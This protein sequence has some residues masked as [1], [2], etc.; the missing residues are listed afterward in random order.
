MR[1][2]RIP[3]SSHT[4]FGANISVRCIL[5][6]INY[7]IESIDVEQ[8][9]RARKN[10]IKKNNTKALWHAFCPLMNYRCV[11][12][13]QL[14]FM[15]LALRPNTNTQ[16]LL[17]SKIRSLTNFNG[18]T[19]KISITTIKLIGSRSTSIMYGFLFWYLLSGLQSLCLF[20]VSPTQLPSCSL[21]ES[22]ACS[23]SLSPR[24]HLAFLMANV[25]KEFQFSAS[26]E[27]SK[28]GSDSNPI[29]K[30]RV[31]HFVLHSM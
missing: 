9:D 19:G 20:I 13:I 10:R 12:C 22:H 23:L 27:M 4:F 1:S 31:R 25:T 28:C 8:R 15:S 26:Y 2:G 5:R 11:S 7:V 21:T 14:N 30:S 3:K 24:S 6:Y 18:A 16:F 29:S 17:W